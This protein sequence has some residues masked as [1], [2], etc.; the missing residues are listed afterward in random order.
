MS[1]AAASGHFLPAQRS[2]EELR[3][4]AVADSD[5]GRRGRHLPDGQGTETHH[6]H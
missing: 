6:E 3:D 5:C 1:A 4:E 2:A